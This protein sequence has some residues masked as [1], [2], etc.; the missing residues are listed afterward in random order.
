MHICISPSYLFIQS[1][2]LLLFVQMHIRDGARNIAVIEK[3]LG[4]LQGKL[5]YETEKMQGYS[6]DLKLA[7]KKYAHYL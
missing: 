6:K 2:Y 1:F 5:Q 7:E 4:E 3:H